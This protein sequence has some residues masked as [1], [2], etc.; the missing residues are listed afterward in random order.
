MP[1]NSSEPEGA[2]GRQRDAERTRAAILGAATHEFSAHGFAGARIERI[3]RAARCNIRLLYHYFGSKKQLYIAVLDAA[4]SDFGR[5]LAQI[6]YDFSDPVGCAEK[7]LRSN[8][9][10]FED[11]PHLEGLIRT[12]E[13]LRGRFL[14]QSALVMMEGARLRDTLA[15]ILTAGEMGGQIRPGVDPVQLY[16][17][18]AA[19]SRFD[20]GN[21]WSLGALLDADLTGRAW[22]KERLEHAV[23]LLRAWLTDRSASHPRRQR[24]KA[25][26]V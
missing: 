15:R 18:I 25:M 4:C 11:N 16:V 23:E 26:A 21:A 14:A 2:A 3:A 1:S 13:M 24:A 17:T 20:L 12:E 5:S 19:L 10:Y 22:R 6:D 8:F 9:R 7:L